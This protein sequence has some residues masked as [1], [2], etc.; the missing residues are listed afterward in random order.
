[1]FPRPKHRTQQP[2]WGGV[3]TTWQDGCFPEHMADPLQA[4]TDVREA[5]IWLAERIKTTPEALGY[6]KWELMQERERLL[7]ILRRLKRV[8][9]G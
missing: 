7:N 4:I 8:V 6:C 3:T 9:S 2:G 1:M 5:L